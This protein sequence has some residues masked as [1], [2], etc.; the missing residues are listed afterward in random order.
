MSIN[1]KISILKSKLIESIF[2]LGNVIGKFSKLFWPPNLFYLNIVFKEGIFTGRNKGRFGSF[3]EGS[4]LSSNMLLVHPEYVYVGKR[5]H[6]SPHVIIEMNT[7]DE[8]IPILQIGDS[9]SFGEFTHITSC[10]NIIIGEGTLTGR[11][12]LITDNSH[13]SSSKDEIN[14]PPLERKN[15]SR[16]GVK[17]GKNVW[18]G[19]KVTI[20]PNV[21]IGDNSIIGANSV[22]SRSIPSNVVAAGCPAKILKYLT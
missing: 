21:E 12:V 3:G 2:L 18:L 19:D 15:F 8:D 13:G 10:N 20:L 9:C 16:G 7:I 4:R 5:C 17:I 1:K 6:F 14:V 22:V 11:F